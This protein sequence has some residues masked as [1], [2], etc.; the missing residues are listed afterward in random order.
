[1]EFKPKN[2]EPGA[3][4]RQSIRSL[5]Y[6]EIVEGRE[7]WKAGIAQVTNERPVKQ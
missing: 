3:E 6:Y 7:S 2:Q 5:P 1:M 4:E